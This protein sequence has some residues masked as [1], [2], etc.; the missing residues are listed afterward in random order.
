M[1]QRLTLRKKFNVLTVLQLQK[2]RCPSLWAGFGVSRE[3]IE[4]V[5]YE[6]IYLLVKHAN[7]SFTEA[8][9]LPA[10]L[11]QWFV[12]RMIKDYEDKEE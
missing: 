11:R 3:Y 4:N 2:R 8:Y 5:V 7:F 6:S 9:S 12:E 1:F 10:P